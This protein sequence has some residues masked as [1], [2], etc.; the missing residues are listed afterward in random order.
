MSKTCIFVLLKIAAI[1]GNDSPNDKGERN[2][3][4]KFD[5]KIS[6]F[7]SSRS[8]ICWHKRRN[9]YATFTDRVTNAAPI[10]APLPSKLTDDKI[11]A[12]VFCLV[13]PGRIG[14][15]RAALAISDGNQPVPGD[16]VGNQMIHD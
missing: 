15:Q 12:A 2:I 3:G 16:A 14:H 8:F 11:D 9:N 10:G 7:L 4:P 6:H 13:R 5:K 1:P